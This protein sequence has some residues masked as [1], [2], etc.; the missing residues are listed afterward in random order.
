MARKKREEQLKK[1]ALACKNNAYGIKKGSQE[2]V[3]EE[4]VNPETGEL[5]AV[6]KKA[7][8]SVNL[9][10]AE[11]DARFDGYFCLITSEMAYDVAKIREVL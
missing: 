7:I 3:L 5:E 10:K 2:Y 9:E 11:N 8:R 1:A 6:S 4:V